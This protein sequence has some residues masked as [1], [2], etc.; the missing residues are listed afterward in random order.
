MWANYSPK[1]AS[2]TEDEE[3]VWACEKCDKEFD[4]EAEA[5]ACC[6]ESTAEKES[7]EEVEEEKKE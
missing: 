5:A 7:E 1:K 6:Q 4:T 2:E 3:E